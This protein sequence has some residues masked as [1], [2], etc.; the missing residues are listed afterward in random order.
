VFGKNRREIREGRGENR[1]GIMHYIQCMKL[2]NRTHICLA[3]FLN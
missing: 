3:T 2:S 1:Q